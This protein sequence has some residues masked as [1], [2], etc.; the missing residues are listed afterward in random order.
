MIGSGA[1]GRQRGEEPALEPRL[2]LVKEQQRRQVSRERMQMRFVKYQANAGR[3]PSHSG[4]TVVEVAVAMAIAG[5]AIG[6]IING[7][8]YCVQASQ[9]SALALAASAAAMQR[10]EETRSV[11]WDTAAWPQ[12]D[13][14]LQ[15]NFPSREV[16]LDVSGDGKVTTLATVHTTIAQVS[17]NPPLK[18][19][20]V[21]CVWQY[22]GNQWITNTI[23]T[24]RAPKQ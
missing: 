20:R 11:T 16:I 8:N 12:V 10:V 24:C 9:K 5:L 4:M 1:P 6:G 19:I 14:L 2:F 3:P 18:R 17:A 13:Q 23:E 15:T 21:D 7:Y 22:R